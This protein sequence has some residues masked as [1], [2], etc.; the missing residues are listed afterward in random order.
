MSTPVPIGPGTSAIPILPASRWIPEA[1]SRLGARGEIDRNVLI[2]GTGKAGRNL[3]AYFTDHPLAGCVV[4]G[5]LDDSVP[6]GGE[7][8]GKVD[9]M[10]RVA[11][12]EF[13]DE[14]VLTGSYERDLAQRVV[15]EALRN[16]LHVRVIPDL[17]GLDPKCL[18]L[19]RLGDLPVLRLQENKTSRV[20]PFLKRTMDVVVSATALIL[21][22]PLLCAIALAIRLESRGPILYRAQ[23]VGKKGR[24]FLCY[25]LRTMVAD[26][27]RE[28]ELLRAQHNE[29]TGPIFKIA[30]DPRITRVGQRLRRYSLDEL[31]QFWNVLRGRMSLVGPR[32]HP[33]DDC[34]H[35]DP[36]HLRRLEVKPGISGLWQVTARNDPSFER[37]MALDLEYIEHWSLYLDLKILCKTVLV[38][39][40]GSGT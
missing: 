9:D 40:G 4:R 35:Y 12:A 13:V 22:A 34:D 24:L 28:K 21:A 15:R 11:L 8:L 33:V 31:P 18:T 19:E 36:E 37:N 6:T 32:P 3:A 38:V 39:L 14:V 30:N 23:R 29:R 17:F 10:A 1:G 5:F 16:R 26:A 7:V 27:D 2:I 25:K 20:G